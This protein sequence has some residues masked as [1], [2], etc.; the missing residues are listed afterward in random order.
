MIFMNMKNT[1]N[2]VTLSKHITI[3]FGSFSICIDV[4]FFF[5]LLIS[6]Y[7]SSATLNNQIHFLLV[8]GLPQPILQRV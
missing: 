3:E 4:G 1:Y 6:E 2:V 5:L 8:G 7:Y